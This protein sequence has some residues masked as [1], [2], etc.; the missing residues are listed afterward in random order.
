MRFAL[1]FLAACIDPVDQRWDLDHDHVVAVRA[2]PP[3]VMPFER[4]RL[5][6]LVAH[7]G[8]A[9]TIEAPTAAV[10]EADLVAF[11]GDGWYVTAPSEAALAAMRQ[12]A[13]I[14][15][16]P[17]PYEVAVQFGDDLYAKK[18]VI[19]GATAANPT[20]PPM[21]VAGVPAGEALVV[22]TGQDVY[23]TVAADR[24]NWLTSC[25]E[26]F[27]DDVATAFLRVKEPCDGELAVV[28]R[29]GAGVAWHV[30]PLH[31]E[32]LP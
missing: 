24:V 3:A 13:G 1:V 14:V 12:R 26:L 7:R 9:P 20:I 31:A 22:P 6:G 32:N 25:G 23:V 28:V 27:Q 29:D 4:A 19:L 2:E 30:W 11:I 10:G 8:G 5:D 15:D 21:L 16:G 18:T 17:V